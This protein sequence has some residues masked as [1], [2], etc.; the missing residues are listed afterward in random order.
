MHLHALG[1]A[2][3]CGGASAHV[4]FWHFLMTAVRVSNLDMQIASKDV[5]LEEMAAEG[6]DP[7]EMGR[8]YEERK[9]LINERE[10]IKRKAVEL[11]Q[12]SFCFNRSCSIA[13]L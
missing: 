2:P 11:R 12:V 10:S 4:D 13:V 7:E 8:V 6:R 5:M 1:H 3:Y 9:A